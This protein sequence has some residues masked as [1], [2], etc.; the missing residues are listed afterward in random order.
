[1]K[2]T[3][4]VILP[5]HNEEENIPL[6]YKEIMN[7]FKH[8]EDRYLHELIFVNDGST[9]NS[10]YE[11]LKLSKSDS[12]VKYVI[13]SRNFGH[14]AAIEAGINCAKGD[15]VIMM[16]ADL[17]HPPERIFDM[18][19]YW[20]SGYQIVNTRR[21]DNEKVGFLKKLTSD[22]FYK[23]INKIS[24]IKI[25][26]GSADFRLIDRKV[27]DV[28]KNFPEKEKF[29]RGLVNWVGFK[30]IL[31]DYEVRAR[32]HGKS[33]YSIKKMINFARIGITSFSMLPIKMILSSGAIL[34]LLSGSAFVITL[35]MYFLGNR[36]FSGAVILGC[37]MLMNTGVIM[38]MLGIN[39][40][41]LITV[42]KQIQDR[43]SYIIMESNVDE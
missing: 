33:S 10:S 27:V 15:A 14:H 36:L 20:E 17:Q 40:T 18:I 34:T 11:I 3:I 43:P 5:V 31:I 35:A 6:I 24:D 42:L 37:F 28:L 1:M 16:D 29:Y 22:T 23:I 8:I 7:V 26:Q 21:L 12:N 41:Y 25:E 39:S 32:I 9:D 2:K 13:F 4:S 38:V 30:S 19:K